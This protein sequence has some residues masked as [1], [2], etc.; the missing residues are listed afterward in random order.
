MPL[1]DGSNL[2][3]N[4]NGGRDWQFVLGP[5]YQQHWK[6]YLLTPELDQCSERTSWFS[7]CSHLREE[8]INVSYMLMM[9]CSWKKA[10][11]CQAACN[12]GYSSGPLASCWWKPSRPFLWEPWKHMGEQFPAPCLRQ[13]VLNLSWAGSF[14][15]KETV[16]ALLESHS[17]IK[18]IFTLD[19]I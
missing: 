6:L 7:F 11:P 8:F 12:L 15:E 17:G 9:Q 3:L 16:G 2:V 19:P 14:S 10:S 18:I 4:F 13:I 1:R 5:W